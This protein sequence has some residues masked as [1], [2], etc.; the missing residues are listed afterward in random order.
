MVAALL[1]RGANTQSLTN[2]KKTAAFSAAK[3]NNFEMLRKLIDKD[4][5]VI[6]WQ[7]INGETV[8]MQAVEFGNVE[9]VRYLIEKKCNLNLSS[10]KGNAL[11]YAKKY[12][13]PAITQILLEAGAGQQDDKNKNKI[14]FFSSSQMQANSSAELK[15]APTINKLQTKST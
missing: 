15:M 12:E 9:M 3:R 13:K 7:D 6:D 1:D 5:S 8:L 4:P 11:Y 14:Q 10:R 2:L